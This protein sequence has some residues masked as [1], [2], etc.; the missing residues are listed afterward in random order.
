MTQF[1]S[2]EL[3]QHF[4]PAV[5][6]AA[7]GLHLRQSDVFGPI[8]DCVTIAQKTVK[9]TPLDKLTDA[10][11]AILTGAHGLCEFNTRLRSDPVLQHAFGRTACADQSVVQATLNACTL[12]QVTQLER[13]LTTIYRQHSQDSA[14]EYTA[15]WQILDAD[16]T[17]WPCGKKA[18]LASKGY[19]P[20]QRE[21]AR[22]AIGPGA[23]QQL[24]RNRGRTVGRRHDL[25]AHGAAAAD[26]GSPTN[27]GPGSSQ[28]R[29]HDC[30]RR[31]GGWQC[32]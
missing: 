2:S 10:F 12:E 13:A 7:L 26:Q 30:A 27:L 22:A 1:S 28:T 11:I 29:T 24:S 18:A 19:F 3:T 15:A 31:C 21:K 14:H 16:L 17:G 5:S 4:S 6:L 20:Q 25:F 9:Y 8:R 32:L 23:G